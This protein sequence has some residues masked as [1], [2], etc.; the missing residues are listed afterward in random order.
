MTQTTDLS[1]LFADENYKIQIEDKP[2]K[3][4]V[5]VTDEEKSAMGDILKN[6]QAAT[7]KAAKGIVEDSFHEPVLGLLIQMQRTEAGV[8]VLDYHIEVE[9]KTVQEGLNKNFYKITNKQKDH[10]MFSELG[11][12]ES[13]VGICQHLLYTGDEKKI[14]KIVEIDAMY[15]GTMLETYGY[16]KRLAKLDDNSVEY[17]IIIAKYLNCK[18]KLEPIKMQLLQSL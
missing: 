15:V 10:I 14:E 16:K 9:K 8:V 3:I 1:D 12:F 5:K 18:S 11:L 7:E 2:K 17:D 6:L 13:A 4:E